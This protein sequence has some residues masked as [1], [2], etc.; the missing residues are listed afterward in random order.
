MEIKPKN[1][2]LIVS[3][4]QIFLRINGGD[5]ANLIFEVERDA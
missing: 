5:C 3:D 2:L 1:M 4:E